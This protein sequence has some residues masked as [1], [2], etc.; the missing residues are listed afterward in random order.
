MGTCNSR[1]RLCERSSDYR[2]GKFIRKDVDCRQLWDKLRL[3]KVLSPLNSALGMVL[4]RLWVKLS[5]VS[6]IRARYLGNCGEVI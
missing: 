2:P 3:C 5:V 1:M 4:M 6:C